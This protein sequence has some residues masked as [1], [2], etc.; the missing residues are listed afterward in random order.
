MAQSNNSKLILAI[1]LLVV[2][3]GIFAFR[4]STR[5]KLESTAPTSDF[6]VQANTALEEA[7]SAVGS[8]G[9]KN[10][11]AWVD[12]RT[13]QMN[14]KNAEAIFGASPSMSDIKVLDCGTDDE[15]HAITVMTLKVGS[16]EKCISVSLIKNKNGKY[17]FESVAQSGI[18]VK[19]FRTYY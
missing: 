19:D 7:F 10:A 16:N 4:F 2:A 3:G 15:N 13:A 9:W 1:V 11:N 17:V 14:A 12:A 18:D 5:E 8:K 6:Q